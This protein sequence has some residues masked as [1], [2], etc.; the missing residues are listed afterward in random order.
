ME[1]FTIKV[2]IY[3]KDTD[4]GGVVYYANYLRYF[5]MARTEFIESKGLSMRK[6]MDEGVYFVV[7]EVQIDYKRPGRYGDILLID[8]ILKETGHTYLVFQHRVRK[9]APEE[10]LLA[11]AEVKIVAVNK[12]LKPLRIPEE[13]KGL[14]R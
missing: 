12:D 13:I 8:T 9:E 7:K 3:Y 5:E 1:P 4:C 11:E 6:L 14:L 10:Q 2:K